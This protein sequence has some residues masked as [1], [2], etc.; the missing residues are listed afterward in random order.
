MVLTRG[1][2][3]KGMGVEDIIMNLIPLIIIAAMTLSLASWT[4]KRNL[5]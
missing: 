1:I 5:D 4:F 3:L 2:F